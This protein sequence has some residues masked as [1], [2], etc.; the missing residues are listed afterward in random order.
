M[1]TQSHGNGKAEEPPPR[2]LEGLVKAIDDHGKRTWQSREM[3]EQGRRIGYVVTIVV[4]A[5]L[6]YFFHTL[7]QWRIPF[8]TEAWTQVLWAFDLSIGATIIGNALM[9]SF[10]PHWY[11]RA[12]SIVVNGFGL[13]VMYTL[14]RVFPFEFGTA[15]WNDLAHLAIAI[16]C[17]GVVIAIVVESIQLALGFNRD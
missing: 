4:N 1:S 5:F 13:L 9:L 11:R 8:V 3:K 10:D 17:L 12:T 14:W 6:L 16:G 15:F 7:P 2:G